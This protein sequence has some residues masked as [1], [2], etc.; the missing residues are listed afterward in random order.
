V[1]VG[2]GGGGGGFDGLMGHG[3]PMLSLSSAADTFMPYSGDSGGGGAGAAAGGGGLR[4]PEIGEPEVGDV[5][6]LVTSH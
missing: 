6:P 4:P 5:L 1:G 2:A 3:M